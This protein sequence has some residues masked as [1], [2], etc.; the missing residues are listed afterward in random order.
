MRLA[1]AGLFIAIP[2]IFERVRSTQIQAD[3]RMRKERAVAPVSV[4]VRGSKRPRIGRGRGLDGVL[5]ECARGPADPLIGRRHAHPGIKL[6]PVTVMAHLRA[7]NVNRVVPA[8]WV[9]AARMGGL[10]DV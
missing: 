4:A 2:A 7:V 8:P 6:V 5:S 1:P 9:V 10:P 3:G